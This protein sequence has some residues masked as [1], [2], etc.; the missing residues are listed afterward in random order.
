MTFQG[1]LLIAAF[2]ALVVLVTKPAGAWLYALYDGRT[3]RHGV[4]G[5]VE[6]GVFAVAGIDPAAE[7]GWRRYAVDMLVFNIAG[8]ALLTFAYL[9]LCNRA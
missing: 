5:S 1:W 9:G 8:L 3:A 2:V 4:L 7:T 6:R